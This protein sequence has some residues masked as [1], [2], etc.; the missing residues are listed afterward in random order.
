MIYG[1]AL[2]KIRMLYRL[3]IRI[4]ILLSATRFWFHLGVTLGI[5]DKITFKLKLKIYFICYPLNYPHIEYV[6]NYSIPYIHAHYNDG[7]D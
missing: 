1:I 2:I 7:H 4:N 6:Q 3:K 5:I